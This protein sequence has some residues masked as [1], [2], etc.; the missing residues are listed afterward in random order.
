MAVH[1]G[2]LREAR[3][4][5]QESTGNTHIDARAFHAKGMSK[6]PDMADGSCYETTHHKKSTEQTIREL[7]DEHS[8]DIDKKILLVIH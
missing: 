7:L 8:E 1:R 2:I 5:I 6:A 3:K 4:R